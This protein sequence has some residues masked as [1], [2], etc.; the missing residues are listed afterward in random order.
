MDFTISPELEGLRRRIAAFVE[1]EI[2]P[3]ETDPASWDAHE[4]I[5]EPALSELRTKA[6]AAGLL[7]QGFAALA[8][9][10]VCNAQLFRTD[11]DFFFVLA[12]QFRAFNEEMRE[13]ALCFSFFPVDF[14]L[15]P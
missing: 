10:F 7:P 13:G 11:A 1:T 14:G 5:A 4:N 12:H 9:F 6:R 8:G 3:R 15:L 2:I